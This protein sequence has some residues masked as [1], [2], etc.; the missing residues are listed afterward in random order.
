MSIS[1]PISGSALACSNML[2]I[3]TTISPMIRI[4]SMEEVILMDG[5]LMVNKD[6]HQTYILL[7][8]KT[9]NY[10]PQSGQT[11]KLI[12]RKCVVDKSINARSIYSPGTLTENIKF[13]TISTVNEHILFK[14]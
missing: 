5:K 13:Q 11:T 14:F 6:N 12:G 7:P 3:K 9:A 8:Q 10:K 4:Q 2:L 1:T